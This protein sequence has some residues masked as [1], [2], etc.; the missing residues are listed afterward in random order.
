MK[1]VIYIILIAA[2]IA[3]VVHKVNKW[4]ERIEQR[5]FDRAMS[6]VNKA[7]ADAS[8][9]R[10]KEESRRQAE[11][12]K[13]VYEAEQKAKRAETLARVE[14]AESE[15]LRR[16]LD[17]ATNSGRASGGT[18]VALGSSPIE[19]VGFVAGECVREYQQ[20]AEAARRSLNAGRTCEAAYDRLTGA[21]PSTVA[22]PVL[23]PSPAT[24]PPSTTEESTPPQILQFNPT[25]V[26]P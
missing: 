24:D 15:R 13:V 5:G 25:G 9:K 6:A 11:K 23:P 8:E 2:A 3:T 17:V 26:T 16:A 20:L 12:E 21:E 22:A 14:R 19:R 1:Y 18:G 10:R 4:E 7:A